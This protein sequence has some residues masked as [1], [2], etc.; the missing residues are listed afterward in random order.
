MNE[1][2]TVLAPLGKPYT[3]TRSRLGA[4][5]KIMQDRYVCDLSSLKELVSNIS[6]KLTSIPEQTKSPEFS[7]LISYDD[8]THHDGVSE[9]LGN[10]TR[11]PIGKQTDRVV[12]HWSIFHK[13]DDENNELTLTIRISNPVNPLVFLQAALS[14][15]ANDVDNIEFEMGSTCVTVDGVP[16]Y[17]ADEIFLRM[18]KWI[19]ARSKPHP[20]ISIS[21]VYSKYEWYLDNMNSVIFPILIVTCVSFYLFEKYPISFLITVNQIVFC[22]YFALQT[23]ANR[24]NNKMALWAKRSRYISLFRITNGDEDASIKFAAIAQNSFLK[25]AFTTVTSFLLNIAAGIVCSKLTGVA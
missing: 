25:L 8:K 2:Q 14:R 17:Y 3:I 11:I 16:H 12:L 23:I 4:I 9:V 6:E 5:T 24:V 15:S 19:D 21:E 18:Q 22:L 7:C 20:Y 1:L 13:I 10:V